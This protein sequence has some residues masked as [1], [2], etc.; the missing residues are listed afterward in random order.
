MFKIPKYSKTLS[1][2]AFLRNIKK[3]LP[4]LEKLLKEVN[5]HWTYEDLVY[6]FYH[7]SF[8]AYHIQSVTCKIV[9]E[10]ST[11]TSGIQTNK[12]IKINPFF[13][14]ILDE[15]ASNKQFKMQH[16]KNWLKYTRP[17]LEAFFHAKYFLE[18]AVKYGKELRRAPMMLPSGWAGLLYL[19]NLR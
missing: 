12:E 4:K 5:D 3:H 1:D 10:L 7:Q 9:K 11:L 17:M 6:R 18:M 13:Q 8:K 16:N 2:Q 14:K 15:G 19:F